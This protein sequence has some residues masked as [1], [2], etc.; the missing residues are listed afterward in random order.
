MSFQ[1]HILTTISDNEIADAMASDD[2]FAANTLLAISQ[3]LDLDAIMEDLAEHSLSN[4]G[5]IQAFA[6]RLSGVIKQLVAEE[7]AA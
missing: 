3:T 6:D 7:D 2:Q 5:E 1:M 4:L